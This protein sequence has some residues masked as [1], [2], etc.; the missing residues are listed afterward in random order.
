MADEKTPEHLQG[1]VDVVAGIYSS[2][3]DDAEY[4]EMAFALLKAAE[5]DKDAVDKIAVYIQ[6]QHQL[7]KN[8]YEAVVSVK[9]KINSWLM[10]A[11]HWTVAKKL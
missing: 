2:A 10:W 1:L 8:K 3:P 5:G 6:K 9:A 4:A 11:E 7:L